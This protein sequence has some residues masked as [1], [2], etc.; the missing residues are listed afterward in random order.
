VMYRVV[1]FWGC[2]ISWI[3]LACNMPWIWQEP[4]ERD[5]SEEVL[6]GIWEMEQGTTEFRSDGTFVITGTF[7]LNG[8]GIWKLQSRNKSIDIRYDESESTQSHWRVLGHVIDDGQDFSIWGGEGD[9]DFWDPWR[10]VE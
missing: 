3:L 6:Y 8:E 2:A 5:V 10:K 4:T 7:T 9:P 1:L